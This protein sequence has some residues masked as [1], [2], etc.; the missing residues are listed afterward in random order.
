MVHDDIE[1]DHRL[2]K[3]EIKCGENGIQ[4]F[5]SVVVEF[6]TMIHFGMLQQGVLNLG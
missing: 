2:V 5:Y 1:G 3:E 4:V 6:L